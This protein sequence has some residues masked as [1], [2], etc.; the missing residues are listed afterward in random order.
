M[1]H[2]NVILMDIGLPDVDGYQLAERVRATPWG[3]RTV[4]IAVTGW[5]QEDDRRRALSAGFDHHLT[6]PVSPEAVESLLQS[7]VPGLHADNP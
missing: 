7:L 1:C 5:G 4:L 3:G 2:P 6:K